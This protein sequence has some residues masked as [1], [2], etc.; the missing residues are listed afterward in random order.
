M[1]LGTPRGA[2]ISI[3]RVNVHSPLGIFQGI[4]SEYLALKCSPIVVYMDFRDFLV[5]LYIL[6][7]VLGWHP[8]Y[9]CGFTWVF[10]FYNLG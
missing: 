2:F 7:T 8:A 10:L 4:L 9:P 1:L 6:Y 3:L 5:M